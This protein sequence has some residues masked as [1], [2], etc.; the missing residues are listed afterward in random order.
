MFKIFQTLASEANELLPIYNKTSHNFYSASIP[1]ADWSDP[2]Q[3][4]GL[5][6]GSMVSVNMSKPGFCHRNMLLGCSI[7]EKE[8]D[9][10]FHVIYN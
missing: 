7:T 8:C 10:S 9:F 1:V 6:H 5:H 2:Q 4:S 3:S